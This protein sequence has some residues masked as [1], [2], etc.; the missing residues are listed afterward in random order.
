MDADRRTPPIQHHTDTATHGYSTTAI[1]PHRMKNA[2]T[3]DAV[4]DLALRKRLDKPYRLDKQAV[5]KKLPR[6]E[7]SGWVSG[8][9]CILELG[10]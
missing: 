7:K 9:R 10:N 2:K 3:P 4:Q 8:Y 6:E 1:Q 5:L